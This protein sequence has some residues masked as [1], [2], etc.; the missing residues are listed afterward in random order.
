MINYVKKSYD[1]PILSAAEHCTG[2]GGAENESH[3]SDHTR[4]II[5]LVKIMWDMS[6][7]NMQT[8]GRTNICYSVFVFKHV[9]VF[10][11]LFVFETCRFSQGCIMRSNNSVCGAAEK[12]EI[13]LTDSVL[14]DR[15]DSKNVAI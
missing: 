8:A 9:F 1:F 11:N 5:E 4:K 12:I 2:P 6:S 3:R 7:K 14:D 13:C 10:L 15:L